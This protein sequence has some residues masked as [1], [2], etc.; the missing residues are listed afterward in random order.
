MAMPITRS[1]KIA[2]VSLAIGA[3][4][5]GGGMYFMPRSVAPWW[6]DAIAGCLVAVGLYRVLLEQKALE[7]IVDKKNDSTA[8]RS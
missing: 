5:F 8:K 2:L 3:I 1:Q 4:V 7:A 6:A